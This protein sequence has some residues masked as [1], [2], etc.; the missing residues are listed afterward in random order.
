MTV[1]LTGGLSD[2]REFVFA[3]QPDDPEMRESVNAWI[4][5][6]VPRSACRVSVSKRSPISGTRTT[7]R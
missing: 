3:E 7:F 5:T 1:D 6:R 4:W 2:E